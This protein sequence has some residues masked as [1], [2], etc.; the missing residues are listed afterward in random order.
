MKNE[1][2]E[3]ISILSTSAFG[4]VAALAWNNLIKEVFNRYYKTGEGILALLIYALVV[5]LIA[6]TITL[7][8]AKVANR[9]KELNLVKLLKQ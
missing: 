2:I 7:I 6:V 5:T 4:L 3:K 8:I 1:V 9:T